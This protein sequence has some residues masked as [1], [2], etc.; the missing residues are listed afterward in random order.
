M[1]ACD[2]R[3]WEHNLADIRKSFTGQLWMQWHNDTTRVFAEK[4]GINAV[5]GVG[6]S[7]LGDGCIKHGANSGH[8]AICLAHTV[9]EATEINLLGFDMGKTGGK[10]HW[11]GDHPKGFTNGNYEGFVDNFNKLASDLKAA[12]VKVVNYSRESRLTQFERGNID[13][14]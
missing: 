14:L 7:G 1:Y 13:E 4:N 5:K 11:F 9:L 3:W 10:N 6:G 8:Q 2:Q 12:G